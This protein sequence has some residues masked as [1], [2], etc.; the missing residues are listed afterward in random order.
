VDPGD[1]QKIAAGDVLILQDIRSALRS[2]DTTIHV[3]NATRDQDYTVRHRLSDRQI[4]MILA[5][6]L[7]PWLRRQHQT[8][9]LGEPSSTTPASL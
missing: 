2:D 7:L 9:T 6:G 4:A 1:Y 8:G 5:G 3:H